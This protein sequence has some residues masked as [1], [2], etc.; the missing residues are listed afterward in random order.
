[1]AG[2][3]TVL[4]TG[5]AGFIGCGVAKTLVEQGTRVLVADSL[6]PQVH[7]NPGRPDRLPAQA[8]LLPFD[9]TEAVAWDALLKLERPGT[10]VH[11]AAETGTSQSLRQRPDMGSST[12]S[13]RPR[14]WMRSPG[15]ATCPRTL[16]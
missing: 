10:V 3:D 4:I 8:E 5:G 2:D 9:V 15:P 1:M 7:A 13:G 11:L 16:S 12:A 14:C 6:H